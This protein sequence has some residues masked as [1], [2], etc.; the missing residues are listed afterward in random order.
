MTVIG[1]GFPP[2]D[3]G[4]VGLTCG[5]EGVV[6]FACGLT[7]GVTFDP[8]FDVIC[9]DGVTP[10]GGCLTAYTAIT[11]PITSADM[12]AIS[13]TASSTGLGLLVEPA[14][15]VGGAGVSGCFMPSTASRSVVGG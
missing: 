9:G 1:T 15:L 4:V 11:P 13:N 7:I 14:G 8:G 6:G 3:V 2:E 12:T 5:T 10:E